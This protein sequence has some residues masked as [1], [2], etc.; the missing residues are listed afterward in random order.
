MRRRVAGLRDDAPG[1]GAKGAEGA[2][3]DRLV[4]QIEVLGGDD[5][6]VV[7]VLAVA[8]LVGEM[9]TLSTSKYGVGGLLVAF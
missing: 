1:A 2:E 3:R 7:L 6:V 4:V 9:P 8:I 5:G